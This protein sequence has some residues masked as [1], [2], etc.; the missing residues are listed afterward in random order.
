MFCLV[1]SRLPLF[2]Q[3]CLAAGAA[4]GVDAPQALAWHA[5]LSHLGRKYG[6]TNGACSV[7]GSMSDGRLVFDGTV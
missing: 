3:D 4:S 7:L 6:I 1:W 2:D 5:G